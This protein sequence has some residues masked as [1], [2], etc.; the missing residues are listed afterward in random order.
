M[1]KKQNFHKAIHLIKEQTIQKQS[2]LRY[3]TSEKALFDTAVL[4][5][6]CD[7]ILQ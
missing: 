1:K 4:V 2:S 6:E 3:A 7:D 5:H